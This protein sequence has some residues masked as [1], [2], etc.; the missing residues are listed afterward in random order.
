MSVQVTDSSVSVSSLTWRSDELSVNI[1]ISAGPY[2]L[3]HEGREHLEVYSLT[4][5][6]LFRKTFSSI[7]IVAITGDDVLKYSGLSFL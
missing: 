3:Q 2:L 7:H 5:G 6:T 1:L 4:G